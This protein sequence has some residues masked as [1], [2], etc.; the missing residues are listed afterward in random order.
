MTIRV[1]SVDDTSPPITT[2]ASGL[3]TSEPVPEVMTSGS[4]PKAVVIAV[5][6]TG[7]NFDEQPAD[8]RLP[9]SLSPRS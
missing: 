2:I 1:S 3:C 7:L 8:H 4:N 5:I 6:R 9:Q